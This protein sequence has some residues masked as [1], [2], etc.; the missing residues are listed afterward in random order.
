MADKEVEGNDLAL[1]LNVDHFVAKLRDAVKIKVRINHVF[2]EE[3]A[4]SD[5]IE[6]FFEDLTDE[7]QKNTTAIAW[8]FLL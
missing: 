5:D 6:K 8:D 7:V 1:L 2:V 3:F 4:V